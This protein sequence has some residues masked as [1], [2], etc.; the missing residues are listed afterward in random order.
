MSE[1]KKQCDDK[2][3]VYFFGGIQEYSL[4]MIEEEILKESLYLDVFAGSDIRFKQDISPIENALEKVMKINGVSWKWRQEE[5]PDKNFSDK[6]EIGLIAQDI[7]Q[8][9][10]EIVAKDGDGYLAI[11][12][13]KI[14]PV[15]TEAVK[16]L[17]RLNIQQQNEIADLKHKLANQ[18]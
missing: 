3:E 5:F 15:L 17:Y 6:T 13:A 10:P 12:Y 7:V 14:T 9:L 18:S 8:V 11:N 4:D 1:N 2:D 16:E